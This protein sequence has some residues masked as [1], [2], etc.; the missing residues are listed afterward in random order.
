LKIHK[1]QRRLTNQSPQKSIMS[2]EADLFTNCLFTNLPPSMRPHNSSLTCPPDFEKDNYYVCQNSQ[3]PDPDGDL[4]GYESADEPDSDYE[5]DCKEGETYATLR[6]NLLD[7]GMRRRIPTSEYKHPSL[8]PTEAVDDAPKVNVV[9][10]YKAP[11]ALEEKLDLHDQCGRM[12]RYV[13]DLYR[14]DPSATLPFTLVCST[15]QGRKV[16]FD[17]VGQI[18]TP[19]H[20]DEGLLQLVGEPGAYM[21]RKLREGWQQKRVD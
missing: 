16:R 18:W 9:A 7:V 10:W 15:K 13:G 12:H 2:T 19:K 14:L 21:V 6:G 20:E 11:Q 17:H 4:N 5:F 8:L 3:S 1:K